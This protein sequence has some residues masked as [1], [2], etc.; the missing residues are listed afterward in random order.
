MVFIIWIIVLILLYKHFILY[1]F[2]I[3][4]NHLSIFFGVP[5]AGKTTIAAALAKKYQQHHI[6]VFSNVPI[7]GC[8]KYDALT[9]LG[10]YK[11]DR[12]AV[13]IDEASICFNNRRWKSFPDHLIEWFKMHRHEHVE[14]LV[15]SQDYQDFDATIKRLAYK[16]YLCRPSLLPF[17]V[18]AVPIKRTVGVNEQHKIDDLYK[19]H[20][21]FTGWIF[22]RNF[23]A[24]LVWHN[25]NSWSEL[26]LPRKEFQKYPD[27]EFEKPRKYKYPVKDRIIKFFKARKV[28]KIIKNRVKKGAKL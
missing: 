4:H 3:G 23:F 27:Q 21:P 12:C 25:F 1:P 22:N 17:F 10:I 14:V 8:Y 16:L 24:P 26:N 11:I 6:K 15:F 13:I 19:L 18:Q 7:K 2:K 9:E 28:F 5:G 20:S